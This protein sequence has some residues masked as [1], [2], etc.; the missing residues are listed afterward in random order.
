MMV[1]DH[2]AIEALAG[3]VPEAPGAPHA[4]RPAGQS[5]RRPATSAAAPNVQRILRVRVPV[6]AQL[7]A[8]RMPI[9][10][11]RKISLGAIIEFE[12]PIQEPLDLL[13]NN[14]VVGKGEAVK[15]GE[16]YGLRVTQIQDRV[17]R[18]RSMGA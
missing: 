1:V 14:R 12:K 11:I 16:N 9:A 5:G 10:K 15:S 6:I 18:I 8:R 2:E 4:E 3:D 13:V 7:A 17:A